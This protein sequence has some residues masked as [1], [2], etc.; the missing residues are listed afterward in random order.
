MSNDRASEARA[1]LLDSVAGKAK[2]VAGAV[3]GKD[4]LVEEGQLQQTE[5]ANRRSAVADDAIARAKREE[6]EKVSE[7]ADRDAAVR[8]AAA[9]DE[10]ERAEA[11]VESQRDGEHAVADQ[12]AAQQAAADREAAE[13]E[14]EQLAEA[15]LREAEAI[16]EDAGT[17]EK[18]ATDE[19]LRLQRAAAAADDEAAR[20]RS[21]TQ[22]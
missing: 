8:K 12:K 13:R 10:A 9:R 7:Q 16:A 20:L 22:K 2:E 5:A 15:R 17:T 11:G 14:A 6:A 21:E 4:D 1:G 18:Q 3:R 19:R